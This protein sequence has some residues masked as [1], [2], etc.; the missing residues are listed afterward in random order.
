[1][2][3]LQPQ[4]FVPRNGFAD[5]VELHLFCFA[6]EKTYAACILAVATAFD[7][8]LK[9]TL[10]VGKRKVAPVKPVSNPS[11]ENCVGLMGTRVLICV[12]KVEAQSGIT[13]NGKYA[14]SHSIT[15]V[16]RLA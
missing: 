8:R 15:M 12:V 1:M 5:S 9:A 13:V 7:G 11:L 6:S 4:H 16:C 10:L 3:D 14:W 2:T